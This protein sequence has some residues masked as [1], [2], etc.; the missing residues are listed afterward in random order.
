MDLF[1]YHRKTAKGKKRMKRVGFLYEKICSEEN[2]K[3]AILDAAKGKK[4]KRRDVRKVLNNLDFYI[5]DIQL[6]LKNKTFSNSKPRIS[7]RY[8][9][10]QDKVREISV[11]PFYPDHIVHHAVMR[12]VSPLLIK[13]MYHYCCANVP[14]RG[15]QR[16]RKSLSRVLKSDYRNTKYCLKID[17]RQF[18]P[19]ICIQELK[20]KL[21]EIIKDSDALWILDTIVD[22]Q[23]K[24]LPLGSYCSQWLANY[25]L[26]SLDHFIKEKIRVAYL[27]R[28][29]D[30][31]VLLDGN[32]RKI[33]MAEKL[34][35][36]F[37][38]FEDLEVKN[39]WRIFKVDENNAID[40][41]GYKFY[42]SKISIRKKIFKNIRRVAV[43]LFR[44]IKLLKKISAK[45]IRSLM[46]YLGYIKNTNSFIIKN[47]YLAFLPLK[48]LKTQL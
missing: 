33:L 44:K 47:R 16:I 46:S 27:Y 14:G 19:S 43:R 6:M 9:K 35:D 30:D 31:L 20:Y 24:G 2:I 13:G 41:V 5:K 36:A 42:R 45:Q 25:Y 34:I 17:I 12:I 15:E 3:L 7:Y 10:M 38:M 26:Q 37:L 40:F 11:L 4:K 18:Y 28:Y 22:L 1:I 29:A 21:R 8:E 39:T 32:R 23:D 48:Q